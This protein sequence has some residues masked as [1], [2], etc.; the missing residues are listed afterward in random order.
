MQPDP[1]IP[2]DRHARLRTGLRLAAGMSLLVF[3]AAAVAPAM[4]GGPAASQTSDTAVTQTPS[5][6]VSNAS[7]TRTQVAAAQ[8]IETFEVFG[9]KNPFEKPAVFP[10]GSGRTD[11]T[12]TTVADGGDGGT[13]PTSEGSTG[14]DGQTGDTTTTTAPIE[15]DPVR[16]QSVAL[17]EVF[18]DAGTVTATVRVGS[19]VYRVQQG[20]TFDG[21]Y[22]VLSLDLGTGCGSFMYG[23]SRFNLCEGQEI[24]K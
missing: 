16:N 23:D 18:D 20:Q 10:T 8:V 1:M 9:G 13:T 19:T 3:L 24:L 11:T 15:T 17:I 7:A 21:A 12:T 22:Q 4:M 14:T 6:V 2:E 5:V